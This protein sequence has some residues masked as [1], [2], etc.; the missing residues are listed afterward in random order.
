[1]SPNA[2]PNHTLKINHLEL[3]PSA[4]HIAFPHPT[5]MSLSF[6]EKELFGGAITASVPA[7][8]TDLRKNS[9]NLTISKPNGGSPFTPPRGLATVIFELNERVEQGDDEASI[10]FHLSD[11][12]EDEEYKIWESRKLAAGEIPGLPDVPA[13]SM[14]VTTPYVEN[15]GNMLGHPSQFVAL[16]IVIIRLEKQKTDIVIT[17]N[18]PHTLAEA[19]AEKSLCRPGLEAEQ[20]LGDDY[21]W[22][23]DNAG[24]ALKNLLQVIEEGAKTF[25]I[26]D[27]GLFVHEE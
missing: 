24:G 8:W 3:H 18:M 19:A 4:N 7:A 9:G 27:W 5:T 25:R 20:G 13:Y 12:F 2:N 26:H 15:R 6:A 10:K 23:P 16:A 1:M 17:A 14:L 21:T 11:I 22:K